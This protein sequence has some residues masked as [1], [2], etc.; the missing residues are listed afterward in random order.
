[1]RRLALLLA[2][3]TGFSMAVT[4]IDAKP[5]DEQGFENVQHTLPCPKGTAWSQSDHACL[6]KK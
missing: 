3:L 4:I 2:S 5:F 1:M 6:P